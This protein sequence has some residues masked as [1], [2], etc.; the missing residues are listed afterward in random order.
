M[1]Q[2]WDGIPQKKTG[3][4]ALEVSDMEAFKKQ[5]KENRKASSSTEN[6]G[7]NVKKQALGPNTKR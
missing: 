6:K 1:C 5:E 7:H 4:L 3:I 2:Y